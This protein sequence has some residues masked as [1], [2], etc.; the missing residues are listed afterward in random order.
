MLLHY[1]IARIALIVNRT[2]TTFELILQLRVGFYIV[3]ANKLNILGEIH[4]DASCKL[5]QP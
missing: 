5:I 4:V 2:R 3:V 1:L